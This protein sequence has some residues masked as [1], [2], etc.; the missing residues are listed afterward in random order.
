MITT[1]CLIGV[2][3]FAS[4]SPAPAPDEEVDD[5]PQPASARV[6]TDRQANTGLR[7]KADT[8]KADS[9]KQVQQGWRE[10]TAHGA[11]PA[12]WLIMH[13]IAPAKIK[14]G[15]QLA[16]PRLATAAAGDG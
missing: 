9:K 6:A 1:T 13:S 7:Q 14:D 4:F 2:M 5:V 3:V 8:V 10:D 11:P 16:A 15:P 12:R